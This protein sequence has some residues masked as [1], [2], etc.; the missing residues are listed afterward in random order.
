MDPSLLLLLLTLA[1]ASAFAGLAA[2]FFGIGGG[3][4][5]VPV[6][7]YIL[8]SFGFP[9]SVRMHMAVGTSLAM[10]AIISLR[11]VKHHAHK[12]S[13]DKL[14]LKAWLPLIAAGSLLGLWRHKEYPG[15]F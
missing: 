10:I 12:G 13:V 3:L 9:D 11:S 1:G 4:I 7:Y 5:I 2:G 8:G 15:I 14:V 6:F